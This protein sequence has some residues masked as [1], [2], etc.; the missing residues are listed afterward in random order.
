[1]PVNEAVSGY[2]KD[3]DLAGEEIRL[4]LM[5]SADGTRV[6]QFFLGL[7]QRDLIFLQRDVTDGAQIDTWVREIEAGDTVTILAEAD[8][9]LLG[10]TTLHH[11]LV[12]WTRHVGTV[13]VITD[14][15]QR[16]RGLGRLLLEEMFAL[17]ASRGV[18]KIVAEMTVEQVPALRLFQQLGF[19]EEGRYRSYVKDRQG[20]PH[21]L[22]VMTHDQPALHTPSS[23]EVQA[24]RPW[25]CNACGNVTTA[26]EAP[27]RCPDCGASGEHLSEA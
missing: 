11:S 27:P 26:A 2:P 12:P 17:A 10:E 3:V 1:M 5:Q 7:P 25:R 4:R 19:R 16:G 13:R 24:P 22:I 18:E 9:A 21:D 14:S 23:S 6:H 15:A 8:G 20:A